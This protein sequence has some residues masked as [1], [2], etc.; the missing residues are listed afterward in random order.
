MHFSSINPPKCSHAKFPHIFTANNSAKWN[1]V[2]IAIKDSVSFSL[3]QKHIDPHG[4]FI[5]LVAELNHTTYTL[6]NVYGPNVRPL[7]FIHKVVNTAKQMQKGNLLICRDFNVILNDDLDSSS[8]V[9]RRRPTLGPLCTKER[10]FD[11]WRCLRTT[12]RDFRFFS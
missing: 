9:Q 7:R 2:L 3:L 10:R 6:V 11:P 8:V 12:K 5:I 4:C 1:G